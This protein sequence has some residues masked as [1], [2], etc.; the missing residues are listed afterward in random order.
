MAY[1]FYC[2]GSQKTIFVDSDCFSN[3]TWKLAIFKDGGE[4]VCTLKLEIME[5]ASTARALQIQI[6]PAQVG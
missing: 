2:A 4:V 3:C 5:Y 1:Y 6:H